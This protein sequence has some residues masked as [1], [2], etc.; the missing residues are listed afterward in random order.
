M[1]IGSV[2]GIHDFIRV[3]CP[4]P[5]TIDLS[6]D[7]EPKKKEKKKRERERKQQK[8]NAVTFKKEKQKMIPTRG[9]EPRA[10]V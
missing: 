6:F 9:I 5:S 4:N 10:A 3:T 2:S 1:S 8:R 7:H